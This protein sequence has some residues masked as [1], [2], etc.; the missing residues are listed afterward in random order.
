MSSHSSIRAIGFG[1]C[2]WGRS[3]RLAV[4]KQ[5]GNRGIRGFGLLY[6]LFSLMG[7]PTCAVIL[8]QNRRRALLDQSLMTLMCLAGVLRNDWLID[9]TT[10]ALC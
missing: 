5:T 9:T 2:A 8:H 6:L 10:A 7:Q 1:T 3:D 4:E